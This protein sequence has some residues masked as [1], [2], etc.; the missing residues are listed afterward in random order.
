MTETLLYACKIGQPNYME[1]ILYECKGYVNK[2]DLM[3]KGQEWAEKNGYDRLRISVVDLSTPPNFKKT[4]K[5]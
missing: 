1:E 4:V 3:K 2:D 5:I